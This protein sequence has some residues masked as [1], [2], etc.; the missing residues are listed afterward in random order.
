MPDDVSNWWLSIP[1]AGLYQE[2]QNLEQVETQ[3]FQILQRYYGWFRSL[4][5]SNGCKAGTRISAS[6]SF[7][8]GTSVGQIRLKFCFRYAFLFS[9]G[10]IKLSGASCQ[11]F[12][13]APWSCS[14]TVFSFSFHLHSLNSMTLDAFVAIAQVRNLDPVEDITFSLRSGDR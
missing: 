5:L 6:L 2:F 3:R 9:Q 10:Q 13:G 7:G 4:G 14:Q 8:E 12:S 1:S 11:I